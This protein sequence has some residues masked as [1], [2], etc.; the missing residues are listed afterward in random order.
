MALSGNQYS[1]KVQRLR[2]YFSK[3]ESMRFTGHLDLRLTWERSLRRSGLPLAYSEGFSPKPLFNFALPLPLGFIS[4]AEIGDFWFSE[5]LDQN[6][7]L[8]SIRNS[9][10]PGLSLE[11]I[12]VVPDLHG[13]K[14]PDL[15]EQVEYEIPL[16][17]KS[18]NYQQ[19]ISQLL[20]SPEII[21]TRRKKEYDLRPLI[22]ELQ[23]VASSKDLKK[24]IKM[25]L[26]ALP[27]ATGRPDEVLAALN[28]D[29]LNFLIC[30]TKIHLRNPE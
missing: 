28:L 12:S 30:R 5:T 6:N 29:A 1:M 14:L 10:P 21:R 27:G 19:I 4:R 23:L 13:N 18:E 26:T 3:N 22:K 17:N 16:Q 11:K 15:V 8:L 20:E 2:F 24:L 25:T 9:L 7:A